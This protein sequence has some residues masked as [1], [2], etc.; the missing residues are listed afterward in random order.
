MYQNLYRTCRVIVLLIKP[1]VLCLIRPCC[2]CSSQ[3]IFGGKSH[4]QLLLFAVTH[5]LEFHPCNMAANV[6]PD[7]SLYSEFCFR[8]KRVLFFGPFQLKYF[9]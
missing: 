9:I 5:A 6:L 1:F 2:I 8:D 7:E 4:F 3:G